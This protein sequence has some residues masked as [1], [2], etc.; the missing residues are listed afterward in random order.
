MAK[1]NVVSAAQKVEIQDDW[2]MLRR[3]D[4]L[5]FQPSKAQG[6]LHRRFFLLSFLEVVFFCSAR[7]TSDRSRQLRRQDS[8]I[9]N[10]L[11]K[12]TYRKFY[13]S[14]ENPN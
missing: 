12:E 5:H 4:Q 7:A 6:C 13:V 10:S 14:R 9:Q 11:H 1:Y 3:R 8:A 2:P